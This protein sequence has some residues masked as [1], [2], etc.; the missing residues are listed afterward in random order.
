MRRFSNLPI[1]RA[2]AVRGLVPVGFMLAI[3]PE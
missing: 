2:F 1:R 3:S